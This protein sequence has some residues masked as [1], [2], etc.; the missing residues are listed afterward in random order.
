MNVRMK[1]IATFLISAFI[2]VAGMAQTQ[3]LGKSDPAAKKILDAV[4]A[5]FK[6]YKAVQ[7]TFTFKS[8]DGKGKVL[9]V[10]K[11]TLYT[12]GN[13]YRVSITGGQDI[14]CDG[15]TV[16]TYDKGA[17]EVTISKFEASANSITPQKLFTNFYDKDF[18]YKLNGE[19][20]E[21]GK[22]LQEIELT[23]VDKSK[24]FFKVLVWVDKATQTIYSTRVME[25]SG[26]KYTYT[27]GSLNGNANITDAQF[28]FNKAKYPGVEV[29][30]LR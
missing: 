13:K 16:S 21:A 2:T 5:K 12:K 11:G 19:K 1:T 14:F 23:P 4:S 27:V 10:K 24:S 30:D 20:K 7:A 3:T 17:N 8:E 25:K 28:V 15:A 26:N 9:G 29:V 18:L 22:T 6:T